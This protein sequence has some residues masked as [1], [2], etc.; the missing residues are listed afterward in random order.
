MSY[1]YGAKNMCDGGIESTVDEI[2][3][4][5]KDLCKEGFAEVEEIPDIE[6]DEDGE[7]TVSDWNNI[8]DTVCDHIASN[9]DE[10]LESVVSDIDEHLQTVKDES[11][12][13]G[14]EL[15]MEDACQNCVPYD[16]FEEMETE[17]DEAVKKVDELEDSQNG[18]VFQGEEF[19][20]IAERELFVSQIGT[21]LRLEKEENEM[22]SICTVW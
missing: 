3:T 18:I 1:V 14:Y 16:E 2:R 6:T 19:R 9:L 5:V 17:R 22:P 13:E 7:K 11:R 10:A 4:A 12:Q 20:W 21:V 15:G 8:P